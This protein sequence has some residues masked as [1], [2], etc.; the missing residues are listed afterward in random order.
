MATD[1]FYYEF[2]YIP[3]RAIY[4]TDLTAFNRKKSTAE[5]QIQYRKGIIL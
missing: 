5:K 2:P 4:A 3:Y 1:A